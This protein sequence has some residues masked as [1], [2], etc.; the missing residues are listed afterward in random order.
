MYIILPYR[1]GIGEDSIL[2]N[3]SLYFK[4][5]AEWEE[6]KLDITMTRCLKNKLMNLNVSNFGI[7][8]SEFILDVLLIYQLVIIY[9]EMHTV[10]A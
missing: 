8:S 10:S 9:M 7:P 6:L 5:D 4:N 2:F 1:A 3:S